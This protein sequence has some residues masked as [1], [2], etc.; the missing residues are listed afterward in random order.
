MSFDAS[1]EKGQRSHGEHPAGVA[2]HGYE[3]APPETMSIATYASTRLST[4]R[5]PMAKAPNPF[6]LLAL[7][8]RQQWLFFLVSGPIEPSAYN[9]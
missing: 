3:R 7:L 4:L 1:D 2:A 6:K 8:N 5:P 9:D